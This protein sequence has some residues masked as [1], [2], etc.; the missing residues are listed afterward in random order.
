MRGWAKTQFQ[1]KNEVN[2]LI[3]KRIVSRFSTPVYYAFLLFLSLF[4]S[5]F[6]MNFLVV[7]QKYATL[8]I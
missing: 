3:I 4:P 2:L 1:E 5:L 8:L 7:A 6:Q